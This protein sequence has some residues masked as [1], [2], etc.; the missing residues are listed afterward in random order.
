MHRLSNLDRF[1][2]SRDSLSEIVEPLF[3]VAV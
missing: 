2:R 3:R 1:D